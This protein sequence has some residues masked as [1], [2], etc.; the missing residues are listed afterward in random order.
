V[1]K[2]VAALEPDGKAYVK[3]MR[4][5]RKDLLAGVDGALNA[6]RIGTTIGEITL[7]GKGGGRV[8]T[9]HNVLDDVIGVML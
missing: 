2:Y 6:V 5:S 9:A 3:P 1:I 4:L 8:E 7:V